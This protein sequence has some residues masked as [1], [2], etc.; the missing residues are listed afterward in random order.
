MNL[1]ACILLIYP[2][3]PNLEKNCGFNTQFL[4]HRKDAE[5][6][7]SLLCVLYTFAINSPGV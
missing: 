7:E 6:R 5:S 1:E 3:F 4:L 2:F